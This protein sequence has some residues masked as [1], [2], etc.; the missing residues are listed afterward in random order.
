MK[1]TEY[2]ISQMDCPTEEQLIRMQLSGI[3][4]VRQLRFDIEKRRLWVT[5]EGTAD[6]ISR[7]LDKL[8]LGAKILET[9]SSDNEIIDD[10]SKVQ[11]RIL[12]Y[13]LL[14]NAVFFLLEITTGI[15]SHSMGLIA[16]SL[17]MLADAFVYGLS[18]LAV[19]KSLLQKKKVARISGY[20]QILLAL[21]GLTEIIRR[22]IGGEAMPDFRMMIIIAS[23]ALLANATCLYL[24]QRVKSKEAHIRA[25][26]IFTSND[27]IINLG[28][29]AAAIF[30]WVL[31]NR[32]PDLI[33]GGIV[34][35]IVMRGAFRILRLGKQVRSS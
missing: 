23:M 14:I 5:H 35:I 19:G 8:M 6:D 28:V 11:K 1:Q 10:Q 24:L 18:L 33:I 32:I 15:I 2:H 25:T 29:I 4:E 12:T 21:A 3:K 31:D 7:E 30:V 20:I 16:D 27:I 26:M 22:F 17:D 9:K 13:V 34:F